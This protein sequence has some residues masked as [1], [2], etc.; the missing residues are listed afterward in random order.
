[1]CSVESGSSMDWNIFFSPFIF[2]TRTGHGRNGSGVDWSRLSSRD[3]ES[4]WTNSR[5]GG[6]ITRAKPRNSWN[7]AF[8]KSSVPF[9]C[10]RRSIYRRFVSSFPSTKLEESTGT[11]EETVISIQRAPQRIWPFFFSLSLA[12]RDGFQR[13]TI[14]PLEVVLITLYDAYLIVARNLIRSYV[15][16]YSF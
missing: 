7:R 14:P 13:R 9:R 5:N 8:A 16:K 2:S 15:F 6:A 12:P 3:V 10:A 4:W 11:M 1:M